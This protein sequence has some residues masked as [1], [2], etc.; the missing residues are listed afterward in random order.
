MHALQ[1]PCDHFKNAVIAQPGVAARDAAAVATAML[2]AAA[3]E[4]ASASAVA[5]AVAAAEAGASSAPAAILADIVASAGS[6]AANT[7]GSEE[8][9]VIA[10]STAAAMEVAIHGTCE[11]QTGGAVMVAASS[12]DVTTPSV[13]AESMPA[14]GDK[15]TVAANIT[16]IYASAGATLQHALLHRPTNTQVCFAPHVFP[17][18]AHDW[19]C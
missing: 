14:A 10:G 6:N 17:T 13:A 5:S 7:I 16:S 8:V 3:T 4:T 19:T 18:S 12:P 11:A 2:N 9:T 15:R 1:E